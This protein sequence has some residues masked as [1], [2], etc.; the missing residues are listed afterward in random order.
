MISK[1]KK[2]KVYLHYNTFKNVII[3]IFSKVFDNVTFLKSFLCSKGLP[4]LALL[5]LKKN[6]QK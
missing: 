3:K 1:A 2:D 4:I 5:P 6:I